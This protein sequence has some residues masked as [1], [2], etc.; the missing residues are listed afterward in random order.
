MSISPPKEWVTPLIVTDCTVDPAGR[1]VT[2]IVDC[3]VTAA[4]STIATAPPLGELIDTGPD[5]KCV[6][7]SMVLPNIGLQLSVAVGGVQF[8]NTWQSV[9][10]TPV[11]TVMLAGHPVITGGV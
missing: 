10:P 1:P 7:V 4:L 8:T 11:V 5:G 9:L 3:V 6:L 2:L